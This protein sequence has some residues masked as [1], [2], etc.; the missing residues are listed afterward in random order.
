M[1]GFWDGCGR[2]LGEFWVSSAGTTVG[3]SF[4]ISDLKGVVVWRR[5]SSNVDRTMSDRSSYEVRSEFVRDSRARGSRRPSRHTRVLAN[6]GRGRVCDCA[7]GCP[8]CR[9]AKNGEAPGGVRAGP[10]SIFF[11]PCVVYVLGILFCEIVETNRNIV[12]KC[13]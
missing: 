1:G 8:F 2:I 5:G 3:E 12:F 7:M 11:L 4:R 6:W 10:L 9:G 13:L